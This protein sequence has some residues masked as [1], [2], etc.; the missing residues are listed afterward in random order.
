MARTI[1]DAALGNRTARDTLKVQGKPH[2][3][4]IE[5]GLHLG[6]RKPKRGA[7]KWVARY[8]AGERTYSIETLATADDFSDA[9]GIAI[10]NFAQAQNKAREGMVER[11][12]L[13]HGKA[14]PF[15]VREA[16]ANYIDYLENNKKSAQDMRYRS[17]CWI[18]PKL[19]DTDVASL[20]TKQLRQWHADI[21]TTPPRVR[22]PKGE[23]QQHR[24]IGKDEDAIRRRRV[25]ANRTL[26][27]LKAALNRAWRDGYVS[28][29]TEWR[30][31][32]P[33]RNV[34]MARTRY[35]TLA[36][37]KR[38]IN[39]ADPE[40][41]PLVQAAL[42]TGAR[43]GEL[44]RLRVADFNPDSETLAIRQS[45]SGNSRHIILTDEGAALFYQLSAGRG[46]DELLLRKSHGG[47]WKSSNQA[48]P[49][50]LACERANIKPRINFHGLR[51]TY[52]SLAIMNGVPLLVVATNLG[53]A[54]TRM[55]ERHYGHL[56]KSY[57]VDAIRAGAPRFGID[58]SNLVSIG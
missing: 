11:A 17:D 40:F 51:H 55:V 57:M 6:Y 1:K 32:E 33:F 7:G 43:Y 56:A 53:H 19:G 27:V 30:R 39:A 13:A 54:D 38:L 45:K 48:V 15:T 23:A 42:F 35:L 9:D 58:S 31:V 5:P 3:R 29:D 37:G 22:T 8:Y 36:E 46:G 25:S 10:L 47:A 4:V 2:Y 52:A 21:A 26:T 12:H 24:Q 18:L 14:G 16:V 49:M 50:A 44:R 20:T 41:R 28:S 34:E